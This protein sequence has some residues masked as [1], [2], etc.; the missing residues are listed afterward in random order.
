MSTIASV[1]YIIGSART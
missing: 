1:M